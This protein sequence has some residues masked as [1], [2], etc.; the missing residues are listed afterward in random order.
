MGQTT[1]ASSYTSQ[2]TSASPTRTMGQTRTLAD[3]S[4]QWSGAV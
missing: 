3:P 4:M 1:M 2:Q